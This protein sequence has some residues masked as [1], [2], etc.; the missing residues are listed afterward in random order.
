MRSHWRKI[1]I[2]AALGV[3]A[4]LGAAWAMK[5]WGLSDRRPALAPPPPLAPVTRSSTVIAPVAVT[6]TAIRDAME[7]GAPPDLSGKADLPPLPFVA[8]I[9]LAWSVSRGPFT[10]AGRPEGLAI[11][12]SLTGSLRAGGQIGAAASGFL[13][14]PGD[15][16]DLLGSLFGDKPAPPRR[17]NQPERKLDERADV[18]GSATLTSRPVLLPQWRMEPNLTSQITI[19]DASLS[20]LGVQLSVPE[21]GKADGRE[22]HQ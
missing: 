7:K 21:E 6:L 20:I 3:V 1:G 17:Q 4:I 16:S 9:D 19:A 12:T 13:G 22:S 18:R 15:L 8:N 10:V 11:S 14:S 5:W 2:G